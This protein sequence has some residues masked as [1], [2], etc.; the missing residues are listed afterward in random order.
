[1]RSAPR[2]ARN[3]GVGGVL[4]EFIIERARANG[5]DRLLV[6]V[7]DENAPAIALYASKGF[8]AT[9]EAGRLLR[10]VSAFASTGASWF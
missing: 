7:A 10:R 4:V 6:D 9:G 8:K 1:M 2:S 3:K 5:M